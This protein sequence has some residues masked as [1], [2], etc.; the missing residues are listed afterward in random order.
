MP[1]FAKKI[2]GQRRMKPLNYKKVYTFAQLIPD[3][4]FFLGSARPGRSK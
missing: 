1:L 2:V 3:I 4:V